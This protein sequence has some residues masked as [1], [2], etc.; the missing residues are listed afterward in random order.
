MS[1]DEK[2]IEDQSTTGSINRLARRI[3]DLQRT[4]DTLVN[5]D[6]TR[7]LM[8][9]EVLASLTSLKQFTITT[10]EHHDVQSQDVKADIKEVEIAVK[11]KV[12]E[13][14]TIL[15]KKKIIKI[16]DKGIFKRILWWLR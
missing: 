15:E 16:P 11:D 1:K 5:K 2:T 8:L 9:E 13:V 3:N 6:K 12:E 7:E 14:T 10:R 4:V